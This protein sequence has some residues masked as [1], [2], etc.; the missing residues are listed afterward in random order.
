MTS[1]EFTGPVDFA[2]F[3]LPRTADVSDAARQLDGQVRAGTLNML[4][5]EVLGRDEDGDVSRLPLT[6]LHE[7][8]GSLL[9]DFV[10]L[11]SD[12]LDADDLA[13]VGAELQPDEVAVVLI[14][15][16]RSLAALAD[17]VSAQG[18]RSLFTGGVHADEITEALELTEES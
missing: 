3:V 10:A 9:D 4:D 15:E 11:E 6:T 1:S 17:L 8:A 2:V 16:D 18:G 13:Q 7:S 5:I 12:L 14:Y